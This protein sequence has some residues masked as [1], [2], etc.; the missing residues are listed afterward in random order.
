MIDLAE[1]AFS[2]LTR[3]ANR[4]AAGAQLVQQL[5]PF[6]AEVCFTAGRLP[7]LARKV[8]WPPTEKSWQHFRPRR[9]LRLP[10]CPRICLNFANA[11][12]L[13]IYSRP[14]PFLLPIYDRSCRIRILD[15]DEDRKPFGGRAQLVQQLD[16]FRAEVEIH[17]TDAGDIAPGRLR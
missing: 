12:A 15:V 13:S 17:R 7:R 5:D 6:R 3:T 11:L 16:P 14:L 4:L 10:A 2:M 8:H 1:S 9:A